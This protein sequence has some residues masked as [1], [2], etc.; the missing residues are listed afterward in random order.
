MSPKLKES[1][2][3]VVNVGI[4]QPGTQSN[5]QLLDK[6]KFILRHIIQKKIFLRPKDEM[7]VILMGSDSSTSDSIT[8]LDNAQELCNMQIGNWNLIKSIEK[9]QPTN[10]TCSWM[11]AIYAA[12]EYIKHECVDKCERKIIL[13]S[14]FNEEENVVDMF[15]AEDIIEILNSEAV[16]L[17]AIGE[18]ALHEIDEDSQTPSEALLMNVLQQINGQYLTFEHAMSD[19][20]FYK[21]PSTKPLPWR[22]L[23]ELGE[24]CIP[25][26]GI[27]KMPS[28]VKLP[29]MVL[30]GKT[31][32]SNTPDKE[33]PI[34]NVVQWMDNNRTIHT[35]EDIIRGY[36]YGGK[37]IPVS[38]EAKKAM[39]PKNNEKSYKIHGF[40]KRENVAMEYWLSDGSYVIVPANEAA[41]APF[42]SLVQ[43]MVD[44]NVIAIVEKVYRANTEAN[45]VALFPSVDVENEPWCLIEIGLPFERDYGAIA[46][47]PLKG[48]TNQLSQEQDN[49]IDDLLRSLELP[50]AADDDTISSSEKYLPG[51]MP[52]PGTQ[53]MWDVLTVRALNPDKPLPPIADDLLNLLEQPEFIKA[54][55]KPVT[56]RI[57]NLFF[58]EKKKPF[59]KRKIEDDNKQSDVNDDAPMTFKEEQRATG[60]NDIDD[61][62]DL[63]SFDF[64]DI[65][66]I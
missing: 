6:E 13:L 19:V 3:F 49:A 14:S 55:C 31:S 59:R 52:D 50:D 22:C 38:D 7:G 29:E 57:K 24:L 66:D 51:Y 28:E 8:G 35:E 23:M 10:Q 17:I 45:M 43:A 11:D 30:M 15:Q 9:L 32:M 5:S 64:D 20:R 27:S 25:I 26:A 54:K 42:Y 37:A 60:N 47:K 62:S 33:V 21:R 12:V 61:I 18:R 34:K 58:L 16:S 46:Q 44:K 2:T 53:H 36:V 39:T 48:M 41:S 65:A 40:T 63:C 56:E 4:V 1:I